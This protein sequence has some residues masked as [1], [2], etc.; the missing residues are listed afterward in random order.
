MVIPLNVTKSEKPHC[1]VN[2][3]GRGPILGLER[4]AL[5]VLAA[6][7]SLIVSFWV[8]KHGRSDNQLRAQWLRTS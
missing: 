4:A 7:N 6:T 8:R 5:L 3:G 1:V 2:N